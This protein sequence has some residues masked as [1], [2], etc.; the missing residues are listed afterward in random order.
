MFKSVNVL[1]WKWEC[2]HKYS[3]S[4]I[5]LRLGVATC[6]DSH[7]IGKLTSTNSL[8]IPL[9]WNMLQ[10]L[11]FIRTS[12]HHLFE[13]S[14]CASPESAS[15]SPLVSPWKNFNHKKKTL[16]QLPES[17]GGDSKEM[18]S[19]SFPSSARSEA[20][21]MRA[22]TSSCSVSK[23]ETKS[24]LENFKNKNKKVKEKTKK[25][26]KHYPS[27]IIIKNQ[28]VASS[29]CDNFTSIYCK[30]ASLGQMSVQH[31]CTL[32][33]LFSISFL[34]YHKAYRNKNGFQSFK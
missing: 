3:F 19:I 10:S 34:A 7:T 20:K 2:M 16:L 22:S 27:R 26:G 32:F 15:T 33:W 30:I 29:A 17:F 12:T 1:V 23:A 25:G 18:A 8:S 28:S 11:T 5:T 21:F 14:E 13:F 4:N 24:S 31:Q 9:I 6:S